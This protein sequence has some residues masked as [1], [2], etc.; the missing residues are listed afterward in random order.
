MNTLEAIFTR[1]SIRK[2]TDQ[3]I[4]KELEQALIKAA[5][6]APN[7]IGNRDWAFVVVRDHDRIVALT[8]A[9]K[10][11]APTLSNATMAVIA[12]GDLSLAIPSVLDFWIEDVSAATEN[13]LLA[14]HS[15]GL[16]G[17]WYGCYPFAHKVKNIQDL[18]KLP[19]N[20]VPMAVI[21]LGY[22]AESKRDDSDDKFEPAK[23]HY[24]EW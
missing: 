5:M 17:C 20:I 19:E 16:G 23:I 11:H 1:R 18:L 14:A 24:E 3:E 15:E 22:P 10:P 6:C 13:L 8:D 2:F 21:G 4:S 12:C 9:L 7:T